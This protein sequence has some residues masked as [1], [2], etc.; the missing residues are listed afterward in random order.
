MHWQCFSLMGGFTVLQYH[1]RAG[2]LRTTTCSL[3]N[4]SF[5]GNK[6]VRHAGMRA[7]IPHDGVGSFAQPPPAS[8]F[9]GH[10]SRGAT[11]LFRYGKMMRHTLHSLGFLVHRSS[12]MRYCFLQEGRQG[13]ARPKSMTCNTIL[14]SHLPSSWKLH[15]VMLE[16]R[17]LKGKNVASSSN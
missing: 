1:D 10:V 11:L 9:S 15:E 16:A 13:T 17:N 5:E 2:T 7:K 6:D 14:Y 12:I 3:T 8:R 4:G